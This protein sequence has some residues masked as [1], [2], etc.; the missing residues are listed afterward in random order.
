MG[1]QKK[2]HFSGEGKDGSAGKVGKMPEDQNQG[3]SQG[4]E[5][6]IVGPA[7]DEEYVGS[8]VGI[9]TKTVYVPHVSMNESLA[10]EQWGYYQGFKRLF[11]GYAIEYY[12]E[13]PFHG[14]IRACSPDPTQIAVRKDTLDLLLENLDLLEALS[15]NRNNNNRLWMHVELNTLKGELDSVIVNLKHKALRSSDIQSK[16]GRACELSET[17]EKHLEGSGKIV[18]RKSKKAFALHIMEKYNKDESAEEPL[19][20]NKRDAVRIIFPLHEF[21]DKTWTEKRCYEMVKKYS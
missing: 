9:L 14:Y 2:N 19:Y 20:R 4:H 11:N 1:K 8:Q 18:W 13:G 5:E 3:N 10:L 15:R 6:W 16:L 12:I 7:S 21:K 17:I